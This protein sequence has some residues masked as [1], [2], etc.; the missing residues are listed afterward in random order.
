MT[1][2]LRTRATTRLYQRAMLSTFLPNSISWVIKNSNQFQRIQFQ[3]ANYKYCC[4]CWGYLKNNTTHFLLFSVFACK[5]WRSIMCHGKV[6]RKHFSFCIWNS[7]E[8][9]N[10]LFKLQQKEDHFCNLLGSLLSDPP[11]IHLDCMGR[12]GDST[13]IV[14]AGNKLRLDVPITGDPAPTVVWTKGEK[15][16]SQSHTLFAILWWNALKPN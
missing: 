7:V 9:K 14:V 10:I 16:L 5:R 11:K 8:K 2:S 3:I 6:Y 13:I 4:Y 1:W 15:V 12:S